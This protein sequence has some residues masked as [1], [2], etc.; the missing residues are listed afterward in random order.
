[1]LL[2]VVV[3]VAVAGAGSYL[4]PTNYMLG[5]RLVAAA[6]VYHLSGTSVRLVSGRPAITT[7]RLESLPLWFA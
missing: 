7:N 4:F 6:L 2:V 1:M 3:V 5:S